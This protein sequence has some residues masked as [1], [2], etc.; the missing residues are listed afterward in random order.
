[1]ALRM[2]CVFFRNGLQLGSSLEGQ[3]AGNGACILTCPY[4]VARRFDGD[5]R[6]GV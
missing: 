5:L 3:S 4:G 1:M 6:S 2:V